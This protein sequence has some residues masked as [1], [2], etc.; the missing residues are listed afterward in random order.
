MH[1]RDFARVEVHADLRAVRLFEHLGHI[2]RTRRFDTAQIER[3]DH[4]GEGCEHFARVFRQVD[5]RSVGPPNGFI[6]RNVGQSAAASGSRIINMNEFD[7]DPVVGGVVVDPSPLFEFED[8][9]FIKYVLACRGDRRGDIRPRFLNRLVHL[10][11]SGDVSVVVLF[12]RSDVDPDFLRR[13]VYRP[14]DPEVLLDQTVFSCCRPI[15]RNSHAVDVRGPCVVV[16]RRFGNVGIRLRGVEVER[17]CDVRSL[18]LCKSD[19]FFYYSNGSLFGFVGYREVVYITGNGGTCKIL[20]D[21]FLYSLAVDGDVAVVIDDDCVV[22]VIGND[23]FGSFK[24][25]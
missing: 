16:D 15:I 12:K 13:V 21:V 9:F 2:G 5:V 6:D 17:R 22:L 11:R 10:F 8:R 24:L 23:S 25:S 19:P 3:S 4:I 7:E 18:S 20:V 14:L 1:G